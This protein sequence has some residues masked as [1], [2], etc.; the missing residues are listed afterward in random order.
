MKVVLIH[1]PSPRDGGNWR[2]GGRTP[3]GLSYI[4]AVVLQLGHEC[5]IIDAESLSMPVEEIDRQLRQLQ[6]DVVGMTC[7]TPLFPATVQIA[8]MARQAIPGVTIVAGGPHVNALPRESLQANPNLDFV[9]VGEGE[10][11]FTRLLELLVAGRTPDHE[12]GLGYRTPD[13]A[14]II[15]PPRPLIQDLD[16]LPPPAWNKL[17]LHAYTDESQF[18]G[19]VRYAILISSRGC[20]FNCTF[21]ASQVTWGRKVRFRSPRRLI[22]ELE[23]LVKVHGVSVLW[24]ADDT[25]TLNKKHV[26]AVCQGVIDAGLEVNIK[27]SSRV[28]TIDA[29]RLKWLAA[30]GC[31]E[32]TFGCESADPGILKVIGKEIRLE[33]VRPAFE[34]VHSFGIQV[35]SSWIIGNPGDTRETIEKTIDFAIDSGTDKAQFT[36]MTPYPGTPL[37][38]T[39]LEKNR[40]Q[41]PD[42]MKFRWYYNVVANLSEVSDQEL[43]DWQQEAYRRFE[44]SRRK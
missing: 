32:I 7:T 43:L 22:P 39:A 8:A 29:E 28:D 4:A 41:A 25:F 31:S 13:G 15:G 17:P 10:I 42:F 21:C 18:P 40:L 38:E 20:P 16:S 6:P 36:L 3:V 44:S 5:T 33:K 12:P 30:A 23:E 24:F 19:G 35:H 14:I 9:V 1:P 37:W 34:L 26:R 27:C 2:R 11:T